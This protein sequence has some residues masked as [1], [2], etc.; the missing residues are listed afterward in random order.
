MYEVFSRRVFA[1]N[2]WQAFQHGQE[3]DW[4]SWLA[5]NSNNESRKRENVDVPTWCYFPVSA[6]CLPPSHGGRWRLES[7]RRAS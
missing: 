5:K 7:E 6:D 1:E 4:D 3:G 2:Y